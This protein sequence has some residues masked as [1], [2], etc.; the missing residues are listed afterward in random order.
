MNEGPLQRSSTSKQKDNPPPRATD[1]F[2]KTI[3][4]TENPRK[5]SVGLFYVRLGLLY[6]RLV[7]VAKVLVAYG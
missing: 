2:S 4:W 3:P 6:L 1:R 5:I 7:L